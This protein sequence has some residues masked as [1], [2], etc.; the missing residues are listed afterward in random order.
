VGRLG[1]WF[2]NRSVTALVERA[3]QKLASGKLEDAA[4]L[5]AAGLERYPGSSGLRDLRL[6]I[7][8]A[9][10]HKTMRRLERRIEINRDPMA[11]EELI[12][13]YL[14]LE[15][16]DEA[17]CKAEAF[18]KEH[19]QR[20][21]SHLLLGEML[22]EVFLDD[23]QARHGHRAHEHLIK[24]AN[25]NGLAV[26]P[27]LL[28]AEFYFCIDARRSLAL[29]HQALERT[30]ADAEAMEA[31][32][33]V[34][35]RVADPEADERLDGLLERIEVEGT[36]R[37]DPADWPLSNRRNAATELREDAADRVVREL[38]ED[39]NVDEVVILRR[40]GSLVT[41]AS[42]LGIHGGSSP[43]ALGTRNGVE[44][45]TDECAGT[46]IGVAAARSGEKESFVDVV[47]T[48]SGKVFPQAR[49][50]DMGK[51]TRCTIRSRQGHVVVGK[52]GNV[53]VGARGPA[54]REP[55]RLWET[56]AHELE[57]VTGRSSS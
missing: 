5:V 20:D 45:G 39:G 53:V 24:A 35:A 49:E 56:V 50:F 38:I 31:T 10:A 25:L 33:A 28:L 23:L 48:V 16:P 43:H 46:L 57:S 21:A 42:P 8:R 2:G 22:L 55:E 26:R 44:P 9:Q 37:R 27:R 36:L 7:R 51:L 15:L 6:S 18:V 30:S 34:L 1:D 47:R 12:R 32:L 40:D 19:P 4:R 54:N 14:E 17:R 3:R 41:H 52:V 13:L 29:I 11:Y